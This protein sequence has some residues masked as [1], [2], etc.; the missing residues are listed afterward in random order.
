MHYTLSPAP[1]SSAQHIPPPRSRSVP[2]LS[3]PSSATPVVM[4]FGSGLDASAKTSTYMFSSIKSRTGTMH[5]AVEYLNDL[6]VFDFKPVGID[7]YVITDYVPTPTSTPSSTPS[8]TPTFSPASLEQRTEHVT[9]LLSPRQH[10]SLQQQ[11]E[12][13]QQ[14]QQLFKMYGSS[15]PPSPPIAITPPPFS[16]TPVSASPSAAVSIPQ[17]RRATTSAGHSYSSQPPFSTTPTS[18]YLSPSTTPSH[19]TYALASTPPISLGSFG[20]SSQYPVEPE[21]LTE[22]ERSLTAG[23]RGS[24]Y[25]T[26][27]PSSFPSGISEPST[28]DYPFKNPPFLSIAAHNASAQNKSSSP[29]SFPPEHALFYNIP[30][31]PSSASSGGVGSVG[32]G[33]LEHNLQLG[34]GL[35]AV[36]SEGL[37]HTESGSFVIMCQN[38]PALVSA[39]PVKLGGVQEELDDLSRRFSGLLADIKQARTERSASAGGSTSAIN[40]TTASPY[41]TSTHDTNTIFTNTARRATSAAISYKPSSYFASSSSSSSNNTTNR[42]STSNNSSASGTPIFLDRNKQIG[43]TELDVPF[44]LD[45]VLLDDIDNT[46]YPGPFAQPPSS[47]ASAAAAAAA[48]ARYSATLYSSG[49]NSDT[50]NFSPALYRQS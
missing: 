18:R 43:M 33:D 32:R 27:I 3:S 37:G 17:N 21:F 2:Q 38:A 13:A 7:P 19:L 34:A 41:N 9:R 20:Y 48:A 35:L 23:N 26:S 10:N 16:C 31:P 29:S 1:A 49:S 39:V 8:S 11:L 36:P 42:L 4:S 15:S 30:L 5:M 45:D 6:S 14:E 22:S 40:P 44:F 24:R 46:D 47:S 25:G 28:P 50:G 12:I